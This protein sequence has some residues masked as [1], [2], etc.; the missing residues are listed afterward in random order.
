M[1]DPEALMQH[2]KRSELST[3][4]QSVSN[5]LLCGNQYTSSISKT[6]YFLCKDLIDEQFKENEK[7]GTISL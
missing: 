7:K 5:R 6:R 3:H 2:E 1:F 4:Y